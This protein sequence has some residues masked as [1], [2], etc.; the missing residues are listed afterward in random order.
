MTLQ[1][2]A[3]LLAL[4]PLGAAWWLG[5]RRGHPLTHLFRAAAALALVLA[6][7]G[8]VLEAGTSGRDL[9]VV[10]DRS[11]SMPAES[12]QDALEL[13]QQAEEKREQ[14][15]RVGVV[16]FGA[17]VRVERLP[18]AT[19]RFSGF[20]SSV[21][22]DASD[23]ATA[24]EAALELIPAGRHGSIVV[25]SDGMV[26]ERDPLEAARR[27]FARGVRVDVRPRS[28]P[29]GA[30]LAVDRLALPTEV[31]TGEPFQFDAWVHTDRRAEAEYVLKRGE[32]ELAR[33]TQQF[34]PGVNRLTFRDQLGR[35]GVAE[36]TIDFELLDDQADPVM[37]NNRGLGAVLV[38]GERAL[39]VLNEDGGESELVRALRGGGM[40]VIV[41]TPETARLDAV[42][43]SLFRAVLLEN[44]AASRLGGRMRALRQF[45]LDRGGGL[46]M[47][48]GR[49]SFGIGGYHLS[50][51]A[52]IL[53][54]SMEMR[55]EHRKLSIALAI[56]M[57]RSGSMAASVGS[58]LTKMDLA[59]MGAASAIELLSPS[60]AI[61]VIAVD[62]SPHVIQ[63]LVQ[64]EDPELVIRRVRRIDSGG[65]G[66]FTYTALL[67]AAREL[68]K[69]EQLNK[70][71]T[72]FADA[73]DAEQPEGCEGLI[74]QLVAAG[75]SIS[76]I[77]LGTPQDSDAAFLRDIAEL[78]G[79]EAYFTT[80]PTELPRLF[81][82]DTMTAA[83]ATF[84]DEPA[85]IELR[86]DLIGIGRLTRSDAPALGGF[87]L[88][89]LRSGAQVGA[90][91]SDEY[92]AP[93][94]TFWHQG[95]GR[96]AAW[97]GQIGGTYGQELV[98]WE[99]FAE[100]FVTLSRWLVGTEEP[101]DVFVNVRREGREAVVSLETDPDAAL[102]PDLGRLVARMALPDGKRR[103]V[104]LERRGEN[105]FEGRVPLTTAGVA[106]GAVELAGRAGAEARAIEIPPI[107]LPHS[108][109]FERSPDPQAG[110]RRMRQLARE[111]GGKVGVNALELL[112]GP[113]T[114]RAWRP[115]TR[116]LLLA[117]LLLVLVEIA[118]R[119]LALWDA[120]RLPR[121]AG[122]RLARWRTARAAARARAKVST[123]DRRG[124][125]VV[126]PTAGLE[127]AEAE[128]SGAP[129]SKPEQQEAEGDSSLTSAL[130]R[131]RRSARR[132]LG[133]R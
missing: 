50:P 98:G 49:A 79:G 110:P 119:R 106:I 61:A 132:K 76:V 59:N 115:V 109:E 35:A 24:L 54:V 42:G 14:G 44:V 31:G 108:P 23:M 125:Q 6:L 105:L 13:I 56:T 84:V 124:T 99:G 113:R 21:Q 114:A 128:P 85:P 40:T 37:E 4:I 53:P 19:G 16:S 77:A 118:G 8:L 93:V 130:E 62:S 29:P 58:G 86:P 70:H 123:A 120:L 12:R 69:A 83:R 117:A 1:Q 32:V 26:T 10:V 68:E 97:T 18:S 47:T 28:R 43:L 72:L 5:I 9:I 63:R 64:V 96:T 111:T 78:G 60:D 112:R 7:A 46:A 90:V 102:A 101:D 131:A 3:L 33:G 48:G 107:A 121:G 81:A 75:T 129:D 82:L 103:E 71:I 127:P 36:Y 27:A 126:A 133:D 22:P 122:Q 38:R 116:E 2:P 88:T 17:E 67:A 51:L 11:R 20:D 65:G 66:I 41:R 95:L 34:E 89:Y 94:L 25:L 100:L 87:N 73:A 74:G 45:V 57:D 39:L 80:D 92:S 30:D 91:T 104:F 15:D 55:Q 52:D